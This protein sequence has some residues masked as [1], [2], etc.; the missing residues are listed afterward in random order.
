MPHDVF[1]S[2]SSLDKAIADAACSRLEQA[3]IRCWIAPRDVLPGSDWATAIVKAIE[4][5]R[6]VV[7][8]FTDHVNAPGP[9]WKEIE[10]AAHH[11]KAM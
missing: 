3:G 1:I 11:L 2:Y 10:R 5:C 7:L 6:V 8:I 4:Q 9:V